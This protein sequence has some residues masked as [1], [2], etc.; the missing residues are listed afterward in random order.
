[1][2]KKKEPPKDISF[3]ST[4]SS[5]AATHYG[6]VDMTWLQKIKGTVN[7]IKIPQVDFGKIAGNIKDRLSQFGRN[8]FAKE[9]ANAIMGN[10]KELFN[11]GK[12]AVKTQINSIMEVGGKIVGQIATTPEGQGLAIFGATSAALL[13]GA[14]LLGAGPEMITG[15]LRMYQLAYA[16]DLRQSDEAIEKQI[17]GSIT[18]LYAVAGETFG[19][20][21]ASFVSGGVFRIPKVQINMTKVT[22][23]WRALNEEARTQLLSQLRNLARTAFFTGLR[24]MTKV[25]YRSSRKWIKELAKREPNHPL[26]QAI[27]GGA[28]AVAQ[29]GAGG[30]PWSLSL[31]VQGK[32]EKLQANPAFKNIGVFLENAIEG[33]GEAIQEFLPELVRQPIA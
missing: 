9:L 12:R 31:Y 30:E 1:M 20:G 7:W 11:S 15:M 26:I 6:E 19:A 3:K 28:A 24:I 23:L 8:G 5:S 17:E 10:L 27:P 2:T 16:L 4:Q 33:F 18:G 32:L 21:L 29:W 22:I 25:F 14:T 13:G